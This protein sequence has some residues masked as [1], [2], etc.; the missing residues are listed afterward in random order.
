MPAPRRAK[1]RRHHPFPL[2]ALAACAVLAGAKPLTAIAEWATYA[3]SVVLT[4]LGGPNHSLSGP[5]APGEATVRRGLQRVD[6]D[7]LDAAIGS[8]LA[9]EN[10]VAGSPSVPGARRRPGFGRRPAVV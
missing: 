5:I 7:A 4:A 2:L 6:G 10:P 3:P 8:W 1:G 9:A